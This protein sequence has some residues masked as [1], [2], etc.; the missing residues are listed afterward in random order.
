[1]CFPSLEYKNLNDKVQKRI[2]TIRRVTLNGDDAW[3][4]VEKPHGD[5]WRVGTR[6]WRGDAS[7]KIWRVPSSK[8]DGPVLKWAHTTYDRSFTKNL[9]PDKPKVCETALCKTFCGPTST[10]MDTIS[11][12]PQVTP[13]YP[14]FRGLLLS[15]LWLEWLHVL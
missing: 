4:K 8:K 13:G 12:E 15:V 2:W 3:K 1:M 14:G 6:A 5:V 10:I 7:K 9:E 11:A